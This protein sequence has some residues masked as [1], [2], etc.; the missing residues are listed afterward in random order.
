[1]SV[2]HLSVVL[3]MLGISLLNASAKMTEAEFVLANQLSESI[4]VESRDR[5][6][7]TLFEHTVKPRG[8]LA[9]RHSRRIV[10]HSSGGSREYNLPSALYLW[11]SNDRLVA[12]LGGKWRVLVTNGP[13]L[14]IAVV[15]A[16][17]A[18]TLPDYNRPP[19]TFPMSPRKESET[20]E[21][22]KARLDRQ[23]RDAVSKGLLATPR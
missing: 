12:T 9:L 8:E 2:K 13:E 15:K 16:P 18:R 11:S 3:V 17:S 1:M 21:Q 4:R 20:F 7:K 22:Y 14:G 10:V 23:Y 19:L 6:G 5:S